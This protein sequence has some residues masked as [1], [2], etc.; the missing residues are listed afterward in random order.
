MISSLALKSVLYKM[1]QNK[2]IMAY[3]IKINLDLKFLSNIN[4]KV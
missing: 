1:L 3:T 2:R 4:W